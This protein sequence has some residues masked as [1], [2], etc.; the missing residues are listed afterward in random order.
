[1]CE[2]YGNI[3]DVKFNPKKTQ[4]MKF[5]KS[6]N[7]IKNDVDIRLCG[8]KLKWVQ[9]FK[10]LGNWITPDLSENVEITSKIGVF[11][12]NVNNLCSTFKNVGVKHTLKLFNSYCCHFY[13]A[14]AWRLRDR[15]ISRIFTAWNKAVRHICNFPPTTHTCYLPYVNG[16]LHVKQDIYLRTRKIILTMVNSKNKSVSFL[17]KSNINNFNSLIGGN[18][19]FIQNELSINENCENPKLVLMKRQNE[20]F[21]PECGLILEMLDVLDDFPIID[22]FDLDE[23]KETLLHI[24]ILS[25]ML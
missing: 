25:F 22:Q 9:E 23:I 10:Y 13:G 21:T 15:H 24:C 18:W 11:F 20:S 19:N 12:G 8:Q 4:C 17:A 3:F 6:N 14:Q 1:M 5:T 2:T 16:H 7:S